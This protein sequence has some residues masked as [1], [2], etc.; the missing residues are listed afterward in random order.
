MFPMMFGISAVVFIVGYLVYGR[1]MANVYGLS[2]SNE[3][4]AIK[5]EDGIDFVPAHPAVLLGHHFASIAGAGPITG[6]IAAGMA[7]GWLPGQ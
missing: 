3:T 2:D 7:F 4:P 1:F 6:P 5:F